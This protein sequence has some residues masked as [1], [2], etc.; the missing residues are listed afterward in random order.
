MN[1]HI[2]LILSFTSIFIYLD[3]IKPN[4]AYMSTPPPKLSR[5]Q[6]PQES[7][8]ESP[9]SQNQN[10]SFVASESQTFDEKK[11]KQ[12]RR[13]GTKAKPKIPHPHKE[14]V[15]FTLEKSNVFGEESFESP[16]KP[17]FKSPKEAISLIKEGLKKLQIMVNQLEESLYDS[18]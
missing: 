5:R 12:H 7:F 4:Q 6:P 3:E 14:W 1:K 17:S 10:D 13:L 2:Y 18:E 8:F 11:D 15:E 9:E 16:G